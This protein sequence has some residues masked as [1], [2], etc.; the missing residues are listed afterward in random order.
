M[1][2]ELYYSVGEM[3]DSEW[4]EINK[5]VRDYRAK[6]HGHGY[7]EQENTSNFEWVWLKSRE[8]AHRALLEEEYAF[9]I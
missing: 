8:E 9:D 4:R 6:H 1:A 2:K 5:A 3:S 7:W